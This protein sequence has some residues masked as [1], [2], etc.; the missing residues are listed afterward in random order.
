MSENNWIRT[1]Q[2][3]L[4]DCPYCGKEGEEDDTLY[5]TDEPENITIYKC[6]HGVLQE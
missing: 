2:E 3:I 1:D 6:N 5:E 4:D